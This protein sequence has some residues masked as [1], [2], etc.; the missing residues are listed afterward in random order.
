MERE[1]KH[2]ESADHFGWPWIALCLALALHVLDEAV[3]DFLSVYN[4]VVEA[5]RSS[6][7]FLPLPTF[8]FST[9]LGGL[10]FAILIL[11]A[12]SPWAFK[13]SRRL[14]RSAQMFAILM[15]GN[16]L[17]HIVSSIYWKRF[18]PGVYSSPLLLFCSLLLLY[19]VRKIGGQHPH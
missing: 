5:I 2:H 18:L 3:H 17:L 10:Y 4:P 19:K 8:V 13:N 1:V 9:W 15:I 12:L 14:Q 6:L 7:F 11:L 16:T